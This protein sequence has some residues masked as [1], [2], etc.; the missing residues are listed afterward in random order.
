MGVDPFSNAYLPDQQQTTA[1]IHLKLETS[2]KLPDLWGVSLPPVTS[3]SPPPSIA[4]PSGVLLL[5]FLGAQRARLAFEHMTS[6]LLGRQILT[7]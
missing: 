3:A 7:S 6:Q 1:L 4:R 5:P 2:W